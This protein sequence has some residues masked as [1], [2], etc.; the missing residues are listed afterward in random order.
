[1]SHKDLVEN[2]KAAIG[3]VF[4]DTSVKKEV[5]ILSLSDLAGTVEDYLK[6]L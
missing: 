5:T 6:S 4:S 3:A 2:A 1:M